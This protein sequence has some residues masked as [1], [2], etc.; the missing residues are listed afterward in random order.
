MLVIGRKRNPEDRIEPLNTV[1]DVPAELDN[2]VWPGGCSKN[3]IFYFKLVIPRIDNDLIH[4]AMF[5][6]ILYERKNF[7]T[8]E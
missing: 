3:K 5:T 6:E 1:R 2:D 7:I 4:T 8:L